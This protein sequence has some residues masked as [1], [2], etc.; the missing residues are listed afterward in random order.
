MTPKRKALLQFA[1][2]QVAGLVC[3][4]LVGL[5]IVEVLA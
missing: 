3:G 2:G 4:F 1:V 5:A